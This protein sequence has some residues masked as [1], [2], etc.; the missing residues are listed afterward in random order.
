MKQNTSGAENPFCAFSISKTKNSKL[1]DIL[2]AGYAGLDG[3]IQITEEKKEELKTRYSENFLQKTLWL[4]QELISDKALF[5]GM[6]VYELGEGGIFQGLW[7]LASMLDVGIEIHQDQILVK[8]QTIEVANFFT[9]DP[10]QLRSKGCFLFISEDG[11]RMVH[12]LEKKGIPAA[13]IGVATHS[14]DRV[15]LS[16]GEQRFLEKRYTDA[17]TQ[18][19]L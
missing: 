16:Y 17:L 3:S 12:E 9:I 6:P 11:Y 1:P 13:V 14:N 19:K 10:Y 15:I 18:L 8:Q 4:K 2:M 5:G 7:D